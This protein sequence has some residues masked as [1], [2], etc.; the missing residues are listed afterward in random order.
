MIK[1]RLFAHYLMHSYLYYVLDEPVISDELYDGLAKYLLKHY[2]QLDHTHKHLI[3]KAMLRCG[4]ASGVS[5]PYMVV[6]ASG[7]L[8]E[9]EFL[10]ESKKIINYAINNKGE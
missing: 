2:D 4:S 7:L 8:Y 6:E 3:T 9:D 1:S 10:K 5:Y